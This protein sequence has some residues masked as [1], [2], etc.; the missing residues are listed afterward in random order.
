[1]IDETI[2]LLEAYITLALE[3]LAT[4]LMTVEGIVGI[5]FGVFFLGLLSQIRS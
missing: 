5:I 2:N 1:M 4:H 3:F